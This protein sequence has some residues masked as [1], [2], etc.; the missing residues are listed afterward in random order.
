MVPNNTSIA[1]FCSFTKNFVARTAAETKVKSGKI[2]GA[3]HT[4]QSTA[5][6]DVHSLPLSSIVFYHGSSEVTWVSLG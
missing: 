2:C 1:S 4:F 5:P 3:G 6:S